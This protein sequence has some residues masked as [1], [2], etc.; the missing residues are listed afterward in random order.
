VKLLNRLDHMNDVI[1]IATTNGAFEFAF[2]L[3]KASG[4]KTKILDVHEKLTVQFQLFYDLPKKNNHL[5][6]R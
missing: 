5:I 6:F 2:E 4:V 3:A 1:D